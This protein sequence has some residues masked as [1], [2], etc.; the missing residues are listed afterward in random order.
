MLGR[1]R[2]SDAAE[3]HELKRAKKYRRAKRQSGAVG[4]VAR[5]GGFLPREVESNQ[6]SACLRPEESFERG[7]QQSP[8][9]KNGSG[10]L[11]FAGFIGCL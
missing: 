10:P 3:V 1:G 11:D 6:R 2:S 8:G 4:D 5:Q 7:L 9:V